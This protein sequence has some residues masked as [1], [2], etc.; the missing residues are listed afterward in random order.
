LIHGL[1]LILQEISL[2]FLVNR[3]KKNERK[4]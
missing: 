1:F 2:L 4:E 3:S